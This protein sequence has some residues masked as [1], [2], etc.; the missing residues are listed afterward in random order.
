MFWSSL[1]ESYPNELRYRAELAR[2]FRDKAKVAARSNRNR[3][4][5]GAVRESIDLF[6]GTAR[7]EPR[8]ERAS[9]RTFDD[10]SEHRGFRDS[11]NGFEQF[12]LTN[13]AIS[14]SKA[15]PICLATE[16]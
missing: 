15:H 14:S 6:G 2:V 12:A 16:H 3:E 1:I 10:S 7:G 9:I 8:I 13:S 5:E 11:I 4:A